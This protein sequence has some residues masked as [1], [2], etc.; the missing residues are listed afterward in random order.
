MQ[1]LG[2]ILELVEYF[3]LNEPPMSSQQNKQILN[4]HFIN[5]GNDDHDKC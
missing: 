3:I 1:I 4:L 2:M 5:A